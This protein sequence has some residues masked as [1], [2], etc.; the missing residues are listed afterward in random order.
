MRHPPT[1]P[2]RAD[3]NEVPNHSVSRPRLCNLQ[4]EGSITAQ[5]PEHDGFPS[6]FPHAA[7]A[8]RAVTTWH[9]PSP[10]RR[11]PITHE[12]KGILNDELWRSR[13]QHRGPRPPRGRGTGESS[14]A[15][16]QGKLPALTAKKK[17]TARAGSTRAGRTS[18]G[19]TCPSRAEAFPPTMFSLSGYVNIP[20]F[21]VNIPVFSWRRR[22]V[23]AP[24]VWP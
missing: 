13:K 17:H 4:S 24:A 15:T 6:D 21:Y 14:R 5:V 2:P 11:G 1:R 23:L 3:P 12:S 19:T 8:R 16:G 20:V 18:P 7:S 10:P 22:T 9:G